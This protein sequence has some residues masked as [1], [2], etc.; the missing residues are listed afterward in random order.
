MKKV[1]MAALAAVMVSALTLPSIAQTQQ[2]PQGYHYD[3]AQQKC[4]KHVE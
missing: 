1:M 4:V 3:T 2:C